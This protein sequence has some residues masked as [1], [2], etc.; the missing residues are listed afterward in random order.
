MIAC[1]CLE[2]PTDLNDLAD[3]DL[4]VES[5]SFADGAIEHLGSGVDDSRRDSSHGNKTGNRGTWGFSHL[6]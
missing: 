4:A 2:R 3:T 6:S 5:P 1:V